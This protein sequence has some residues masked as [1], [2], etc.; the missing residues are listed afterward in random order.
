MS[1]LSR[2]ELRV[3]LSRDQVQL[4]H[5]ACKFSLQGKSCRVL[6]KKI[7]P[8]VEDADTPWGNAVKT[9]ESALAALPKKPVAAEVI[10]SNHFMHY[11]MVP[12]SES[13]SSEAEE[14][15]YAKHCFSQLYGAAAGSWELRMS[16]D[17]AGAPEFASA[18][19][20]QLLQALRAIFATA[21]VKLSSVQ[22]YLMTAYNN[23]H[24]SLANQDAWFVLHE[25]GSL[26]LG[27]IQQGHWSSVRTIKVGGDWLERLPEILDREVCLS[28]LDATTDNIFLWAPEHWTAVLPQTERWKIHKMQ[29]VIQAGFAPE[30]D[31]RFAMAMCG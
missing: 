9:L 24:A 5:V 6:D 15:A 27:L 4:L 11:A 10:L 14:L 13:L 2:D 3:V 17:F 16:Q 23:C 8:C 22:P 25:Q 31:A 26:C 1:L 21:K 30:Y 20:G 28:E 7:L 19:D 29:P 12:W 18:L